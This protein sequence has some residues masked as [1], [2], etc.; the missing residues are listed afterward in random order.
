MKTS[1]KD[2]NQ[3]KNAYDYIVLG[4][5]PAGVAAAIQ[6]SKLG[7]SVAIVEKNPKKLGGA[8]LH[9]GTIPSKTMREVVS[10]IDY[11]RPHLEKTQNEQNLPK[12]P[13]KY[14]VDR[15]RKVSGDGEQLI[16][17]HLEA[18]NIDIVI[19]YGSIESPNCVK[20]KTENQSTQYIETKTILIA[21][22]SKPRRPPEVIFDGQVVVDSDGIW[23]VPTLPKTMAI[24]GAGIIG[25]EYACYF[26]SLGVKTTLVDSRQQIMQHM[27]NEV[28][29]E[30]KRC[31]ESIG[32][33]F[34][35]GQA[36]K[37][38]SNVSNRAVIELEND[39]IETE[40][41]FFAAGR[42]SATSDM[43]LEKIGVR[44]NE[45]G[46]ILVND[47]F[48]TDVPSIYAAGDSI[49]PPGLVSTSME[50]GRIAAEHAIQGV[51]RRLPKVFPIGMFTIPEMSSVGMSEEE[52][53]AAGIEYVVGRARYHEVARG[54]IRED[55]GLLKI[56]I[57]QN[58]KKILGIHIV[59][60]DAANLVHIGQCFMLAGL[61][62]TALV[63]SIVFSYPTLAEAYR[64]ATFNGINKINNKDMPEK[65]PNPAA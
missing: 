16:R 3:A 31:M 53:Q 52:V 59:G 8:R 29:G 25:S 56:I 5:G 10:N 42:V 7:Q 23:S 11:A 17:E 40:I 43:D 37:K 48:Q 44:M 4:S 60:T 46:A 24:F 13:M 15:V 6:A 2:P 18:N 61:P 19:G 14:I 49:G 58:T 30:L 26:A 47:Y 45:R 28:T 55:H 35:L 62:V 65:K 9:Y 20:V 32:I 41:C 63:D 36:M 64:V 33:Q 54:Y 38:I 21:M 12:I 34:V 39:I 27:D 51:M 22:G 1:K 57:D 50:Q